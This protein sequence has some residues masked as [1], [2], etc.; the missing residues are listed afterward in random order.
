MA[1]CFNKVAE[2]VVCRRKKFENGLLG[3]NY[4]STCNPDFTCSNAENFA[5]RI[6]ADNIVQKD[7]L[8]WNSAT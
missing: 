1:I 5:Q 3:L 8:G 4:A 6:P 2:N 7:N